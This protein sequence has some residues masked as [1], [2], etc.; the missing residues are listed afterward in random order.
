[1]AFRRQTFSINQQRNS[2][3]M[4][5]LPVILIL[6]GSLAALGA[7]PFHPI[8]GDGPYL[9]EGFS[10]DGG[11]NTRNP[12]LVVTNWD[13][14]DTRANVTIQNGIL[15]RASTNE[16]LPLVDIQGG[17]KLRLRDIQGS[18]GASAPAGIWPNSIRLK[19]GLTFKPHVIIEGCE[20]DVTSDPS[21]VV[22]LTTGHFDEGISVEFIGNCKKDG[23]PLRDGVFIT[24]SGWQTTDYG[25]LE[26]RLQALEEP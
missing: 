12:Q 10:F 7:A 15:N 20:L 14:I 5:R 8:A 25:T 1:M 24:G 19:T 17:C 3:N 9:I 21:E 26:A 18:S 4:R 6:F 13:N 2:N 23:T 22:D 11:D 16:D